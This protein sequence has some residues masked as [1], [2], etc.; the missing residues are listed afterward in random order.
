MAEVLE[1][2]S[3]E[4]V[5]SAA[6]FPAVVFPAAEFLFRDRGASLV[7]FSSQ[8]TIPI[9]PQD[10]TILIN[11]EDAATSTED[12]VTSMEDAVIIT[13]AITRHSPLRILRRR[14]LGTILI[15]RCNKG[16]TVFVHSVHQQSAKSTPILYPGAFLIS[17]MF[18]AWEWSID[19]V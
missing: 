6:V 9:L 2:D 19:P 18:P 8:Y 17:F 10:V 5:L 7:S 11:M 15:F 13:E 12:A 1:V 3:L 14:R 16:L 4:A